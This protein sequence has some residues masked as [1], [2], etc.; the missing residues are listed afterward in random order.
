MIN[1]ISE[2]ESVILTKLKLPLYRKREE[3]S[4]TLTIFMDSF[5]K[6]IGSNSKEIH[7]TLKENLK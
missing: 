7:A 1:I 6:R 2:L 4:D 3:V 5:M